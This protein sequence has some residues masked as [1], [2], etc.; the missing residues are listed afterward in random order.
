MRRLVLILLLIL[1]GLLAHR[2]WKSRQKPIGEGFVTVQ[3]L[4]VW[5]RVAQVKEPVAR[6]RNGDRVWILGPTAAG[7]EWSRVRTEDGKEGWVQS[8]YLTTRH[9]YEQFAQLAETHKADPPQAEGHVRALSNLRIDP[10]RDASRLFQVDVNDKVEILARA[11]IPAPPPQPESSGE[12]APQTAEQ[13][14]P[15]ES[16]PGKEEWYLVR[17]PSAPGEIPRVG[18]LWGRLLAFDPPQELLDYAEEKRFVAWFVLNQVK[19]PVQ[20]TKNQYLALAVPQRREAESEACDFTHMRV[21]TWN[22]RAHRY[23]TAFRQANICGQWPARL[24]APE[25][26]GAG[27]VPGG[28]APT[29]TVTFSD[30]RSQARERTY[31]LRQT[32]VRRVK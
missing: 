20:G 17:T 11:V 21:F 16:P 6:L 32:V 12:L 5:S 14:S 23:E 27:S 31:Q 18:W 19:D 29:F 3:T 26:A 22:T 25:V 30:S 13:P 15:D 9:I 7:G 2:A 8:Q 10:G 28:P 24:L 1:V 4:T